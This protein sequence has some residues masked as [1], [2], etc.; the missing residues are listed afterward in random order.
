MRTKVITHLQKYNNMNNFR[1]CDIS[2]NTTVAQ[3]SLP[4]GFQNAEQDKRE[5]KSLSDFSEGNIS[6]KIYSHLG[7]I[8][9]SP[10]QREYCS[11]ADPC[12]LLKDLFCLHFAGEQHEFIFHTV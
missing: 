1:T 2:R 7:K 12:M 6:S 8:F 3:N 10:Y 5:E 11:L 9:I 4:I